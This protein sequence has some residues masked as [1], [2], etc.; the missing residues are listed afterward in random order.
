MMKDICG[1]N[2]APLVLWGSGHHICIALAGY[3]NAFRT[4]GAINL[5]LFK[6]KK[7][8]KVQNQ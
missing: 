3:V 2:L 7:A 8:P 5:V 6:D 1:T 4:F